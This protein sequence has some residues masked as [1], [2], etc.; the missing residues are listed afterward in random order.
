MVIYCRRLPTNN[1]TCK[2]GSM[3]LVTDGKGR[4]A[5]GEDKLEIDR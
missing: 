1:E 4:G 5:R 2:H 3:K